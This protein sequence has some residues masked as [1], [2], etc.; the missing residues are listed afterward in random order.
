MKSNYDI[1]IIGGGLAGLTTALQLS[2]SR[3]SVLLIDKNTFPNQKVCGEYVSNEVLPYLNRL[4]VD[5]LAMGAKQ[6]TTL[7]LSTTKGKQIQVKLPLGGF[8]I[9]RYALDDALY[10]QLVKS[11][12]VLHDTVTQVELIDDL[13]TVE[14]ISKKQFHAKYVV[15]AY[16]KRS[17]LDKVLHRK[18]F[19]NKTRWMAVKGHYK[20]SF[21]DNRV[22]L[23]H[24]HGG[25]CGL[26][27]VE[28]GAVNVCYLTTT[29]SFK[30]HK[31]IADFEKE[32]LCKNPYLKDFYAGAEPLFDKPLTISQI[33]FERK[34]TVE[35]HIFM[36][37]DSASLIHP[38]CGN[39]MAMAITAAKLLAEILIEMQGKNRK[40][41]EQ[42]YTQQWKKTFVTRLKYGSFLQSIM[43]RPFL[44]GAGI[45]LAQW[46]PNI[47]SGLIAETHGK[48][49]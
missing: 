6:I 2:K 18:F 31:S 43:M 35:N 14:T 15:G 13:F 29:Q 42:A 22:A 11:T 17:N 10:Q 41:I 21:P 25:Y 9:S 33:S 36:V 47:I 26:S 44:L 40:E 24:F 38:L 1:I 46:Q 4:G 19:S 48:P 16:G 49:F 5:P 3:L 23:H 30:N 28:T 12:P 8:G 7:Q 32:V 34:N 37:G 20:G 27:K 39:G 45:Q